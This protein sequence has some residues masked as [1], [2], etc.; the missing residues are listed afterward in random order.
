MDEAKKERVSRIREEVKSQDKLSKE[1][2]DGLQTLLDADLVSSN[3]T[4]DK[5]GALSTTLGLFIEQWVTHVVRNPDVI[6]AAVKDHAG[7]CPLAD[8][9][10]ALTDRPAQPAALPV[11]VTPRLAPFYVFR[12]QL[13][14]VSCFAVFS[15][16]FPQILSAI[17]GVFK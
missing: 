2:R 13:M 5:I 3:G 7:T 11:G 16:W 6:E 8:Q 12:W 1:T 9:V 15:P 4:V 14:T 10:K 17:K